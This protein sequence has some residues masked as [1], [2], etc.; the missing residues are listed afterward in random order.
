MNTPPPKGA[1]ASGYGL[2]PDRSAVRQRSHRLARI[3]LHRGT[4]TMLSSKERQVPHR[5]AVIHPMPPKGVG[6]PDPLSGTLNF[7]LKLSDC[8]AMGS[9]DCDGDQAGPSAFLVPQLMQAPLP[10]AK[11]PCWPRKTLDCSDD[12][13]AVSRRAIDPVSVRSHFLGL[14]LA[15]AES[16]EIVPNGVHYLTPRRCDLTKDNNLIPMRPLSVWRRAQLRN[17]GSACR[18]TASLGDLLFKS[19]EPELVGKGEIDAV[20]LHAV[21]QRGVEQMKFKSPSRIYGAK[22]RRSP[23]RQFKP[24][25]NAGTVATLVHRRTS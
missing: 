15:H 8:S 20:R 21:A 18:K 17:G 2:T 23:G 11:F 6:F 16:A 3:C 9:F 14:L 10:P 4:L 5:S 13:N 25:H 24:L 22:H 1:L 7:K 12:S 19:V